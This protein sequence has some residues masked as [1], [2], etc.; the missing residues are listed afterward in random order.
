MTAS[1]LC[2]SLISVP[3]MSAHLRYRL[4]CDDTHI[5]GYP[6]TPNKWASFSPWVPMTPGFRP[7]IGTTRQSLGSVLGTVQSVNKEK[8]VGSVQQRIDMVLMEQK[9]PQVMK[10]GSGRALT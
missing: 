1:S 3:A 7:I 10:A 2:R 5:V 8:D 6:A 9:S 4:R